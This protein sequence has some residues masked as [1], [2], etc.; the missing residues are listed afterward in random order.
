MHD[1][2]LLTYLGAVC[3]HPHHHSGTSR[4]RPSIVPPPQKK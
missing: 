4:L 3:P 1:T 2:Y